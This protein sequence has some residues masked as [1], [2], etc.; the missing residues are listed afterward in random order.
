MPRL[1]GVL[2]FA[3]FVLFGFFL[4]TMGY[5]S[6]ER[7]EADTVLRTLFYRLFFSLRRCALPRKLC[8]LNN[9]PQK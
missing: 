2:F 3:L 9:I 6:K 1:F 5:H 7:Q 8:L 4:M